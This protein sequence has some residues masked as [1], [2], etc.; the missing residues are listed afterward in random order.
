VTLLPVIG[1]VQVGQQALAD[2]YTYVPLIGIF[3]LVVW[4]IGDCFCRPL[5]DRE[6]RR[7]SVEDLAIA[8]AIVICLLAGLAYVQVGYWRSSAAL[9]GHALAINPRNQLAYSGVAADLSARGKK[10]EAIALYQ[11]ALSIK[12]IPVARYNMAVDL[13]AV[14]RK[15]EAAVEFARALRYLPDKPDLDNQYGI[16]L[17]K[18]GRVDDA[19]WHFKRALRKV[20]NDPM[21]RH[22]LACAYVA[23]R[24]FAAAAEQYEAILAKEPNNQWAQ[25]CLARTKSAGSEP[26][27]PS[28]DSRIE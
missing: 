4:T 20:P 18:R 25:A 14:G 17:A 23:K 6:A 3:V 26:S 27:A 10:A 24:D 15:Q 28:K 11:K 5:V 12:D 21:T 13:D 9:F 2:R 1:L 16:M 22:N 19:I 7:R 8:G